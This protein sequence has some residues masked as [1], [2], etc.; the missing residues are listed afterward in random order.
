ML[1]RLTCMSCLAAVAAVLAYAMLPRETPPATSASAVLGSPLSLADVVSGT[2][3]RPEESRRKPKVQRAVMKTQKRNR[4]GKSGTACTSRKRPPMRDLQDG[5][6]TLCVRLCDGYYFPI[7]AAAS[8]G[9]LVRDEEICAASCSSP[10]R[11]FVY[12]NKGGAPESMADLDGNPY[13]GLMTAYQYRTSY[14][15]ACTCSASPWTEASANRHRLYALNQLAAEGD[16]TGER[17]RV[18]LAAAVAD[19]ESEVRA[20]TGADVVVRSRM[21]E[22]ARATAAAAAARKFAAQRPAPVVRVAARARDQRRIRP[23]RAVAPPVTRR[24]RITQRAKPVRLSESRIVY[25]V[26]R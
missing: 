26:Q 8:A 6:R 4:C 12:K 20:R 25:R 22:K 9:E 23:V 11:L 3:S 15:S 21:T 10:A 14:D 2:Y 16:T 17:Q 5:Y 18:A 19:Q 7:S 1:A 13:D 24:A